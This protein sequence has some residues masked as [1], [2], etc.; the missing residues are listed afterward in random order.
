MTFPGLPVVVQEHKIP[1]HV[2]EAA[3]DLP[4]TGDEAP[5]KGPCVE[6]IC[7]TVAG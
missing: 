3:V 5:L 6:G 1:V 4:P 2:I 7:Q